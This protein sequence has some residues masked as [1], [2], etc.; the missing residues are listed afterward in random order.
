MYNDFLLVCMK[1]C[2][3][4]NLNCDLKTISIIALVLVISV[5]PREP[6]YSAEFDQRSTVK[7]FIRHLKRA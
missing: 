2:V 5:I 6:E 7:R 4:M 1:F 3:I